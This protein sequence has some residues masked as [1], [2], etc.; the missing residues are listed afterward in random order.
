MHS[1]FLGGD[2]AQTVGAVRGN[3]AMGTTADLQKATGDVRVHAVRSRFDEPGVTI[4][5]PQHELPGDS[6][7]MVCVQL[8]PDD[9]ARLGDVLR[10]AAEIARDDA[11]E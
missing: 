7:E 10:Q 6:A 5:L 3:P 2:L 11:P 8:T 4:E 9:A 1:N